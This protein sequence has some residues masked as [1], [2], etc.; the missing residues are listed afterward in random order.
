MD[1]HYILDYLRKAS[2]GGD[3]HLAFGMKGEMNFFNN[4]DL[5]EYWEKRLTYFE[6]IDITSSPII[7]AVYNYG[8]WKKDRDYKFAISSLLKFQ[9]M[10]DISYNKNWY[11]V[12]SFCIEEQINLAFKLSKKD[13]LEKIAERIRNYLINNKETFPTHTFM[14]NTVQYIRSLDYIDMIKTNDV[15]NIILEFFN[16]TELNYSFREGFLN[17][18]IDIK[19][20][21]KNEKEVNKLHSKMLNL[22]LEEAENKGKTSKLILS[23]LLEQALDYCMKFVIEK[24]ICE[25]IKLRLTKIDYSDELK[26]I[27]LS[28]SEKEKLEQ[29]YKK[30]DEEVNKAINMYVEKLKTLNPFNALYNLF[31]DE[32][33]IR[34]N[35]KG[36]KDF[37][38]KLLKESISTILNTKLDLEYKRKKLESEEDKLKYNLHLYLTPY[39]S[40][41]IYLITD[42]L[43]RLLEDNFIK[44]EHIY[45]LLSKSTIIDEND[46][47]IIMNGVMKHF[48]QDYLSSVSILTP[49]IESTLFLYLQSIGADVSSYSAD[50]ISKRTLGG[51]IEL[52]EIKDKFSIDFQYFIKLFLVADDSINFR[53]RLSHGS[54][55]IVEFNERTSLLI[56]FILLKIYAKSYSQ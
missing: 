35:V 3:H 27:E 36:T 47:T 24:K 14:E 16:N 9:E 50:A 15:Y 8:K 56:I 17:A 33:L 55:K 4:E 12:F 29:A 45:Y 41:A 28:E 32:S 13:E 10:E 53:N 52:S 21:Q 19:K 11:W 25:E 43:K 2:E 38:T 48:T 44:M 1:S 30:Y 37:A 39:L 31:S 51:L 7:E 34:M 26:V 49:K 6:E 23:A 5:K 42:I 54:V 22:K 20:H 46:M 18:C 40:E